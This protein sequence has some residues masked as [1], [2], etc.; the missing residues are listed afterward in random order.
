MAEII[1]ATPSPWTVVGCFFPYGDQAEHPGPIYRRA[2]F[3]SSQ[4]VDGRTLAFVCYGTGQRNSNQA[5]VKGLGNF[6]IEVKGD[7]TGQTGPRLEEMTRFDLS[8]WVTLPWDDV[9]FCR[10]GK[11]PVW[12]GRLS[13]PDRKRVAALWA[14]M[15]TS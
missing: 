13:T 7:P 2:L 6:E 5:A 9:W 15:H 4:R 10:P 3:I 1:T 12:Y 8:R 11:P 14:Q